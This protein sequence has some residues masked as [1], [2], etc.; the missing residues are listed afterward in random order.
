MGTFCYATPFLTGLMRQ[1]QRIMGLDTESQDPY[2][3]EAHRQSFAGNSIRGVQ[4]G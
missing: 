1:R 4:Y 2:P 3:G